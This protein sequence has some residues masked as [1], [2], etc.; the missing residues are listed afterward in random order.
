MQPRDPYG[1]TGTLLANRYQIEELIGI[2]RMAVVYRAYHIVSRKL[3]AIKILKPDLAYANP[4]MVEDFLNEARAIASLDHP[5]IIEV[6][7]AELAED[8][9]AF[10]A[11][12]YLK[13][14]SLDDLLPED[15][16]LP[17]ERVTALFAQIC[18]AVEYAH[19]NG[20]IH[21]DLKPSNI[22]VV[23]S[24]RGEEVIK[25]LDFGIAKAMNA[26]TN[27][28]REVGTICY[29]SPEQLTKGAN[30]DH[31]SDIYSL[32]VILYQ[33]LTGAVPYDDDSMENIIIGILNEMC[34]MIV[35]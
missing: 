3:V 35:Q 18:E 4:G 20:I 2:G 29:A 24:N 27:V 17:L 5:H 9:T 30:I 28:S 23:E 31:R 32:G 11:M 15:G 19:H 22:M 7:D 1:F 8:G 25:I 12:K 34:K 10:M 13:G 21:R 16:S 14:Q 33:M 6:S 26:T